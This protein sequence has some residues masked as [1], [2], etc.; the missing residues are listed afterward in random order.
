MGRLA[1]RSLPAGFAAH[2]SLAISTVS[3]ETGSR[4]SLHASITEMSLTGSLQQQQLLLLPMLAHLTH[5]AE[6]QWLTIVATEPVCERILNTA[7]LKAVG[8]AAEKIRVIRANK[9]ED[10]LWISWEALS[11]GNSHTVVACPGA[12]SAESYKQLEAAAQSGRCQALLLRNATPG[13]GE[14]GN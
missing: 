4:G 8:A 6:D 9:I 14:T 3:A 2:N 5:Q 1:S 13:S 11:L 7:R 12:I 10:V